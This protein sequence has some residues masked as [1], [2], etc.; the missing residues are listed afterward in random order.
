MVFTV[1]FSDYAVI[2]LIIKPFLVDHRRIRMID[3]IT[4][5]GG[6]VQIT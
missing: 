6:K 4:S 2:F 5:S 3:M 1:V